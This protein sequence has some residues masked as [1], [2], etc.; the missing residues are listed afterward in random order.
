[1]PASFTSLP[2][3][4]RV[5]VEPETLRSFRQEDEFVGL[6]ISLMIE[7]ASYACLAAGTTG[8]E[9][10]W[11]RDRAVVGGNMV[12][13]YKLTDVFLDQTTKKR[14]EVVYI[15]ARLIFETAITIEY[16]IRNFSSDLIDLYVRHSFRHERQLRDR[17]KKNILAR[18]GIVSAYRRPYA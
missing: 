12:R 11:D 3:I 9:P 16:L 7:I 17:I 15:L 18:K 2:E 1:M 4:D 6:G 10:D 5:S 14:S 13:L 8:L